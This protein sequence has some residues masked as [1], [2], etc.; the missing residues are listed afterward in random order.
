MNKKKLDKMWEEASI[1][2]ADKLSAWYE[3]KILSG[4]GRVLGLFVKRWLKVFHTNSGNNC[5]DSN[6]EGFFA[7]HQTKDAVVLDYN[8]PDNSPHWRRVKDYIRRVDDKTL[9]GRLNIKWWGSFDMFKWRSE[10]RFQGYFSL[11]KMTPDLPDPIIDYP[12]GERV[13]FLEKNKKPIPQVKHWPGDYEG[14]GKL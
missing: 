10:Y 12:H 4:P 14:G 5:V 9:I 1:P 3:V 8:L 2:Q 13:K 6:K 11:T 7:L